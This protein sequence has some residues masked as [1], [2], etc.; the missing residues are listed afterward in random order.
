MLL[1]PPFNLELL[2]DVMRRRYDEYNSWSSIHIMR[3][4]PRYLSDPHTVQSGQLTR[5]ELPAIENLCLIYQFL[6][7]QFRPGE[8]I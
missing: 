4:R 1:D 6:D 7:C 8:H 3:I 2:D 5:K